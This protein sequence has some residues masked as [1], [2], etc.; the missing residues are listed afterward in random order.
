M[1]L[2]SYRIFS[3]SMFGGVAQTPMDALLNEDGNAI[4]T[5]DGNFILT[6]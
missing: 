4:L 1:S 2:F 6:E 5:E 3:N